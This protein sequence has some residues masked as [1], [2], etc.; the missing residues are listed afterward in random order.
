MLHFIMLGVWAV[1]TVCIVFDECYEHF[2]MEDFD[3]K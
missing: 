3:G 1:L 2:D